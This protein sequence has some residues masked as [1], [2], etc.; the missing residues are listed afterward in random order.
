MLLWLRSCRQSHEPLLFHDGLSGSE[1]FTTLRSYWRLILIPTFHGHGAAPESP[2]P[3]CGIIFT[4]IYRTCG[5][6]SCSSPGG[7]KAHISWGGSCLFHCSQYSSS[8][9]YLQNLDSSYRSREWTKRQV[10]PKQCEHFHTENWALVF[11]PVH[12]GSHVTYLTGLQWVFHGM[13]MVKLSQQGSQQSLLES[14]LVLLGSLRKTFL[15]FILYSPTNHSVW[16]SCVCESLWAGPFESFFLVNLSQALLDNQ[17]YHSWLHVK[18][19]YLTHKK[20]ASDP[21]FEPIVRFSVSSRQEDD[22][23]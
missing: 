10:P 13:I 20:Q 14:S 22:P 2:R 15:W 6:V 23:S 8:Y 12:Q 17:Y 4:H 19:Q 16:M 9:N 5:A 18:K 3:L 1:S 21:K 7:T 11:F